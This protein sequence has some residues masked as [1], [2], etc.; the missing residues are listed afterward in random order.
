MSSSLI[1]MLID[2]L[3]SNTKNGKLIWYKVNNEYSLSVSK[4]L[5]KFDTPYN[6]PK[7]PKAFCCDLKMG[8]VM[9]LRY[10]KSTHKRNNI[11]HISYDYKL[12]LQLD[13]NGD[14]VD[15][16]SFNDNLEDLFSKLTELSFSEQVKQYPVGISQKISNFIFSFLSEKVTV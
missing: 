11:I 7:P 1:N 5:R 12:L 9:I 6:I 16:H 2:K 14:F 4:L 3:N 10:V 8:K 13:K 15:I